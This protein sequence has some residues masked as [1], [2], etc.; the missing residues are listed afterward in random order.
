MMMIL[1][2][3]TE[4]VIKSAALAMAIAYGIYPKMIG[5]F[6][7]VVFIFHPIWCSASSIGKNESNDE[8]DGFRDY[9]RKHQ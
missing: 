6:H 1:S 3:R 9:G 7:D 8:D 5:I 4:N 2:M